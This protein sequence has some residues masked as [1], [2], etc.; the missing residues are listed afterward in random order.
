MGMLA[1]FVD[2]YN[3]ANMLTPSYILVLFIVSV[4]G[5]AWAVFTLF[6]YHRSSSNARFVALVD[7]GFVGAFIAGVYYLRFIA[8]ADCTH[9]VPGDSLDLSF[10]IFGSAH[11]PGMEVSADKT[12]SM[13]KACFA[14][15]IMNCLFFFCT[16]LLAWIHGDHQ[17]DKVV[18][19]ET[20]NRSG[21]GSRQHHHRR[22]SGS[23]YSHRS[24]HSHSRSYV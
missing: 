21:S 23:H 11:L 20:R 1:W 19:H 4:L 13:L 14:F 15:G 12:C 17:E 10:G 7:L 22:R 16:A 2:G 6:S 18:Y 3:K 9:I 8:N 24:S 5:L